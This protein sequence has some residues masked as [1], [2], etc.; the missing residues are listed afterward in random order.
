MFGLK[1]TFSLSTRWNSLR[2]KSGRA[3]IEEIL[4]LGFTHVELGYD[5]TLDLVPGVKEMVRERAVTVGSVHN[6]CPVP[7]GAPYGHPEIFSLSDLHPRTRQSAVINT[8]KS[9]HFAAEM[10]ASCVVVHCGNVEMRNLTTKLLKLLNSGKQ[11]TTAY[12]KTRIKLLMRREKK[13]QKHL[14]QLY[15]SLEELLPAFD[16]V[17]IRLALENL[18]SWES[19][20]SETEMV[21]ILQRFDSPTL[22]YWHDIGHGQV[23]QNLGFSAHRQTMDQL[24]SRVTGIHIHD[25]AFPAYDHLMPPNGNIDFNAFK[26]MAESASV[27]VFE[28]APGTPEHDMTRAVETINKAWNISMPS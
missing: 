26:T 3:L 21:D 9:A 16:D 23:R 19:I 4:T 10:G 27:L 5:L 15:K 11:Q 20:P 8:V 22:G 2:H 28:P 17:H 25:V 12:D 7:L 13:I 6:F 18:P 24:R 1:M 14:A